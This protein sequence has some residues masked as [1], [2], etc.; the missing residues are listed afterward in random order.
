MKTWFYGPG[1]MITR[2]L[3]WLLGGWTIL[4]TQHVP[5]TGAFVL[6]AN[7]CSNADPLILGAGVGHRQGRLVHFM[8]KSEMRRW[9]IIGFLANAAGVFFVRRGEGDRAAQR[10]ALS[11][12]A[13]GRPIALFPEGTR[14][15]DGQLQTG[16]SGAA[17][18]AMRAGVPVIPVGI[19]GTYRLFAAGRLLPRRTP[20]TV[21]IGAPL[22][23]PH[24]PDGR[25]DREQ[26]VAANDAIMRAIAALLPDE[27]RGRY[28]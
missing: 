9:P 16:K 8:A 6:V 25:L 15:R 28:A 10:L 12:L 14:S 5:A 18:L 3:V 26:L 22:S 13:N 2:T 20:M 11:L 4:G 21:R 1:S 17:L 27:Q 7:H 24:V 23:L 19:A